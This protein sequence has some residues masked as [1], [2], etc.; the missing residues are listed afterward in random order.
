[1]PARRQTA[2]AG[3]QSREKKMN[4]MPLVP[5][6]RDTL[7]RIERLLRRELALF[8]TLCALLSAFLAYGALR[9]LASPS[10]PPHPVLQARADVRP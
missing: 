2:Q 3:S 10:A 4:Q 7:P 1:M 6:G 9:T 5:P 8:F